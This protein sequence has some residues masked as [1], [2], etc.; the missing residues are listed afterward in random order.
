MAFGIPRPVTRSA[1]QALVGAR[2]ASSALTSLGGIFYVPRGL[3]AAGP[4]P[5]VAFQAYALHLAQFCEPIA[6]QLIEDG[7][8]DVYF[9]VL[10]H[11]HFSRDERRR[12]RRFAAVTLGLEKA[13][14]LSFWQ[15]AW[16]RFDMWIYLDVFSAFPFRSTR[17]CLLAHGTTL[18]GRFFHARRPLHRLFDFDV[19]FAAGAYDRD[20]IRQEARQH[21]PSP[22]IRADGCPHMDR[23][24][25]PQRSRAQYLAP[26]G[27]TDD[28]PVVLYAPHWQD[29]NHWGDDG[30]R[31]FATVVN[32]LADI[33]VNVLLKPHAMC[34]LPAATR[35]RPWRKVV[36]SLQGRSVRADF[37]E[38]D[39]AALTHA[40]V[41]VTGR[42][43]RTFNFML[44][45]KPVVLFPALAPSQDPVDEMRRVIAREAGHSAESLGELID[46]V[47]RALRDPASGSEKRR[48]HAARLFANVG[49]AT[50]EV[51]HGIYDELG[52]DTAHVE[53]D[54]T[55]MFAAR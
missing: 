32:A 29:L 47:R 49:H 3:V 34:Y 28:L 33:P 26:L 41:L 4:K 6:R 31:L 13:R 16:A 37:G 25:S 46:W 30:P 45:D 2:I 53:S 8:V 50:K 21:G 14:M 20:L 5:R 19:V 52:L 40:D 7:R 48:G 22:V 9:V 39:T 24:L 11:P 44:L 51:V 35:G 1:Q 54:V 23:L 12:I 18:P 38:D 17:K 10:S 42:S 15:T 36:D 27:F 43:S 55:P